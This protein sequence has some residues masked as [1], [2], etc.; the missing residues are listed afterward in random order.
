MAQKKVNEA[1]NERPKIRPALTPEGRE[2]QMIALAINAAEK[3]LLDG[4][5]S[6]QVI[7]HYLKL[8]TERERLER[9]KMEH[10]IA[11]ADA[12]AESL[13]TTQRLENMFAEFMSAYKTYSGEDDGLVE[14]DDD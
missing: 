4:T 6:S 2:Q 11:L 9:I 13:K 1:N 12:K 5:A 14:D 7:T 8:G 3:Q 10:E